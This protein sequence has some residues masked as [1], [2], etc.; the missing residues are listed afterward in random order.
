MTDYARTDRTR[1][2][3]LPDRGHYD[4]ETIYAILDEALVCHVGFVE[5][6]RPFVI[7]T[8]HARVDDAL[9]LHGAPASRLLRHIAAG[10][11]VS[12]A[13][14]IVD[15]LV[16]A[17]SVFHHSVNYRSVVLFG[18]GEPVAGDAA[19]LAALAAFT[20]KIAPGRWAAARQPSPAE[21]NATAVIRIAI[22]EASA[23]I[24]AG[25]PKDDPEDLALDVW[26]GVIPLTLVRGA[27][28][29]AGNATG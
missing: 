2:R 8:L 22:E 24:R 23:K 26:A 18:H 19:K 4:R 27:P 29:A 21:L 5:G 13:A 7:P 25:G 11:E 12:V 3:R 28:L 1:V 16:L 14:T 6:S 15:G 10:G 20:E 17:K 9:F